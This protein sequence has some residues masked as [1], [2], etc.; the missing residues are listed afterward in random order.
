MLEQ[1]FPF[2]YDIAIRT[3]SVKKHQ[4]WLLYFDIAW[5]LSPDIELQTVFRHRVAVLS[6]EVPPHTQSGRLCEV[7]ECA[8]WW[9][10]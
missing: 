7:G 3:S 6:R 8:E 1:T 10:V 4:N 5:V 2:R 9:F